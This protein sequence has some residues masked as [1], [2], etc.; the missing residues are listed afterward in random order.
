MRIGIP[1]EIKEGENRVSLIPACVRSL[2]E[3][4]HT[5][6][7]ELDAGSGSGFTNEEYFKA[8][9]LLVSAEEA[10]GSDL[11]VKVKE[12]LETEYRFFRKNLILFTFLHLAA[13]RRLT[14]ALLEKEVTAIAYE[15]LKL[16]DGTLPLLIPMSEIAG[17]VAIQ[18]A[19]RI[20]ERNHGGMGILLGGV[21]GVEPARVAIVGGGTVGTN[22]LKMA[23]G[24][25]A[26]LTVFDNSLKK[27]RLLD[28]LF[29]GTIKTIMA[30]PYTIE[31]RISSF[32]LLIGAVLNPG[33]KSPKVISKQMIEKMRP[34]SVV[35]DISIDQGG[36]IETIDKPT[37]HDNP[38]FIKSGIIHYAVANIPAAVP[39]TATYALTNATFYWINLLATHGLKAINVDPAIKTAVNTIRGELTC[40][41][42]AE[43]FGMP[44]SPIE[45]FL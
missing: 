29:G 24:L 14:E 20:L 19:A 17:R 45:K 6:L 35:M 28:D 41:A 39:R 13:N 37:T 44:W 26:D 12:P 27:L 9:A 15:T 33:A 40:R 10:W 4:G 32:D 38:T 2:V 22:A 25:G 18:H 3:S 31:E 34:G 1:K 16:P 7:V 43:A 23:L 36:C 30:N 5:I 8:G 42:V 21:P 11:V